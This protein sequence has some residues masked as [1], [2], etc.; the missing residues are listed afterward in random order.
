M[1]LC[2][3][4]SVISCSYI[5]TAYYY[6]QHIPVLDHSGVPI[7]TPEVQIARKQHLAAVAEAKH[8]NGPHA[9]LHYAHVAPAVLHGPAISPIYVK[10]H[11]VLTPEGVPVDTPDVQ[12]AKAIHFKAHAVVNARSAHGHGH[13]YGYGY[14]HHLH[15]RSV[16]A[17]AAPQ[18]VPVI[19]PSGVPE[20]TPEVK[21]AKAVHFAAVAEAK[22]RDAHSAPEYPSEHGPIAYKSYAPAV[23]VPAPFYSHGSPIS[24]STLKAYPISHGHPVFV[25]SVHKAEPVHEVKIGPNGVPIETPEVQ[26]AKAMHFAAV[27]DAKARNAKVEQH[28]YIAYAPAH[29]HAPAHSHASPQW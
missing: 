8:N 12:H 3:W 23:V 19:G 1:I 24:Y 6:P 10:E 11:V 20:E 5:S 7:D 29:G 26:H 2:S 18:H 17:Y 9:S 27:A 25:P 16:Y 15:K 28:H 22:A 13:D 4:L 14:G 21:H